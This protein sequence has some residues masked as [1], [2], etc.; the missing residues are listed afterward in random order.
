MSKN[1]NTKIIIRRLS[2]LKEVNNN[3][4]IVENF[5]GESRFSSYELSWGRV[6]NLVKAALQAPD[7]MAIFVAEKGKQILGFAM[8][9]ISGFIGVVGLKLCNVQFLHILPEFRKTFIGGKALIGLLR[10]VEQWAEKQRVAEINFDLEITHLNNA[11]SKI[12]YGS[13]YKTQNVSFIRIVT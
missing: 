12:F 5:F 7:K 4:Q 11:I 9:G 3:R 1:N 8:C 10:G 13:G 2:T 6:E